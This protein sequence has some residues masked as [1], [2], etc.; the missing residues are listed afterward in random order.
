VNHSVYREQA[1]SAFDGRKYLGR[2]NALTLVINGT[3]DPFVTVKIA[4]E[5]TDGD[6]SI[7]RLHPELLV[8]HVP[9]FLAEVDV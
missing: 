4:K 3:R 5:L 8:T 6:H 1:V 2:I 9:E 7:A